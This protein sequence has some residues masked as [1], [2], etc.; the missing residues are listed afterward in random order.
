MG[1]SVLGP[2]ADRIKTDIRVPENLS[3]FVDKIAHDL[4]VPKNAFY[5]L[6]AAL[7]LDKLAHVEGKGRR[8]ALLAELDEQLEGIRAEMKRLG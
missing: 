1:D 5:V 7:L 2:L 4:G 6:G 3:E 8:K